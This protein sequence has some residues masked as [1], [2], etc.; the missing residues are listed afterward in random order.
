MD[1]SHRLYRF[2][3]EPNLKPVP[4]SEERLWVAA[5][6]L[7]DD[8]MARAPELHAARFIKSCRAFSRLTNRELARFWQLAMKQIPQKGPWFPRVEMSGTKKQPLLQIRI[9]PAPPRQ[10]E[11]RL[12]HGDTSDRRIHPRHK[13]P[14]IFRL[15]QQRKHVRELGADEGFLCT[16]SGY[17]LEGFFS[18]ILWWED[19]SL[20]QTPP[21]KRVLPSITARLIR[22]V[23]AKRH[24]PFAWRFRRWQ[25]LNGREIWT[26]NA[27]HGIRRV[28]NWPLAPWKTAAHTDRDE[29]Q[30]SLD[31]HALRPVFTEYPV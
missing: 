12:V 11:V 6:F 14:D 16:P 22:E 9:R 27:L 29:W 26:V 20:C 17:M 15:E 21:S 7:V 23:A 25:E 18:S 28:V 5:S 3:R 1:N 19:G 30:L 10:S 13:G 2:T 31:E 8:G 4:H 24:V